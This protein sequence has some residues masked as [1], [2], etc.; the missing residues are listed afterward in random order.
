MM[1][2]RTLSAPE[3]AGSSVH[4]ALASSQLAG[5]LQAAPNGTLVEA[6]DAFLRLAGRTREELQSGTLQWS[7][8]FGA[9]PPQPNREVTEAELLRIDGEPVPVRIEVFHR[10]QSGSTALVLD[11]SATRV[12]E[13]ALTRARAVL[14]QQSQQ[15]FGAVEQLSERENALE[16]AARSQHL[17]KADLEQERHRVEE[18]ALQLASANRELDA[19][20]YSVSHDLRAPLRTIDGFSR[21]LLASYGP[22]LDDRA[23]DYLQ[24]VRNAT[25]RM[26]RL[27]DDLLKLARTSRAAMARAT[28][29]LSSGA[30]MIA[31]ELQESDPARQVTWSIEPGL[32]VRGDRALLRVVLENLLGNAWKFTSRR[33]SGVVIEFGRDSSGAFFVR[34]NGA[35]FDMAY[36]SQLFGPFQ[37]LHIVEEFEGTGIGLATVQR[38]VHRH[39]GTVWAEGAPGEGAT[40]HFTLENHESEDPHR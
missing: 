25:Q 27:L 36:A 5:V 34:D 16:A 35:G 33:E 40:I 2:P 37:R 6:N 12:A 19:F 38:I 17:T 20:S 26:A 1:N 23:R 21:V 30:E 9:P 15:L 8:L 29:D 32:I 39:G 18:L 11:A 10:D 14:E 7:V 24:R 4:E 3:G 31:A 28:V 22:M 13:L